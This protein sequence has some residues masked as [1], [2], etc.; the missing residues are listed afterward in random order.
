MSGVRLDLPFS[1]CSHAHGWDGEL[2]FKVLSGNKQAH[3]LNAERAPVPIS[4]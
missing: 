1:F 3:H 2:R 4:L